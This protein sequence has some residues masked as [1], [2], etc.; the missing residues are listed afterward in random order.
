MADDHAINPVQIQKYLA[1]IDYPIKKQD[2]I[3]RAQEQNAPDDVVAVLQR[4]PERDYDAPTAV[5]KA[6]SNLEYH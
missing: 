6:V 2:L 1:G 4:L 3:Q 5:T